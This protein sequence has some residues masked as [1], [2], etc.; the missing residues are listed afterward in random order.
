M[1]FAVLFGLSTDYAVFL[2]SR[3]HEEYKRTGDARRSVVNGMGA[4]SRVI[5]AAASVMVVV[6]ASFV[7]NDQRTVNLFGFGL[8]TAI[9]MYALVAMF[10]LTPALLAILGRAAW[11]LPGRRRRRGAAARAELLAP[12][13]APAGGAVAS[14]ARFAF[15]PI[16][17]GRRASRRDF[18]RAAALLRPGRQLTRQV[19]L[20]G[21]ADGGDHD[22]GR[23]GRQRPEF[24]QV[25]HEREAGQLRG[26]ESDP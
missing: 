12:L 11:W 20:Q 14:R 18:I 19:P 24:E 22:V 7:L 13:A 1:L 9:A 21:R 16:G 26:D 17:S 10:V 23:G 6:F 5:M 2:L 4:T 8:A 3:I 15:W 25:A